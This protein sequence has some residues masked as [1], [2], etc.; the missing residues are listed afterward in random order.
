MTRATE[1]PLRRV[2]SSRHDGELVLEVR[3]T[4]CRLRPFRARCGGPAEVMLGWGLIYQHAMVARAE[5]G[6]RA[7][8]RSHAHGRVRR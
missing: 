8:T 4:C 7:G 6:R 3:D 2:V 5:A 1:K